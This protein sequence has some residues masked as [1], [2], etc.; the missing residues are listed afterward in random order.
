MGT[1]VV[2]SGEQVGGRDAVYILASQEQGPEG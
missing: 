1:L 2:G